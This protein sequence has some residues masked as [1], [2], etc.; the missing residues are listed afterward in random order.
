[1]WFKAIAATCVARIEMSVEYA[2]NM[3]ISGMWLQDTVYLR[4]VV[5]HV[6]VTS[7]VWQLPQICG[8]GTLLPQICGTLCLYILP[9]ICGTCLRYVA[10]TRVDRHI[11][12]LLHEEKLPADND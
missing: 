5:P 2:L 9:L 4:Y 8:Y 11:A 10:D 7:G 1:M 3:A 6:C 12:A